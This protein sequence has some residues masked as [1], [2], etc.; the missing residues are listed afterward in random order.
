MG[1]DIPA[2]RVERM[3]ELPGAAYA[4]GV[5]AQGNV[6]TLSMKAFTPPEFGAIVAKLP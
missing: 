6:T 4:L 3:S 2:S 5:A 1:C